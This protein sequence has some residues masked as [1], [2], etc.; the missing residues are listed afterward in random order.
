MN[1]QNYDWPLL[2]TVMSEN[3]RISEEL[4]TARRQKLRNDT[5]N[6]AVRGAAVVATVII[7]RRLPA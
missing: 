7:C 3:E 5:I 4:K 1:A 2:N 6:L